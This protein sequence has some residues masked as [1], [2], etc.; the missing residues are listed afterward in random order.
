MAV[1]HANRLFL[2]QTIFDTLQMATQWPTCDEGSTTGHYL[3][4]ADALVELLEVSDCGSVGGFDR[5]NP[6]I[7]VTGCNVFD[8]FLTLLRK[9]PGDVKRIKPV[10]NATVATLTQFYTEL[11]T[12]RDKVYAEK[13]LR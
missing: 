2:L 12:L 4:K 7:R 8:R 13:G 9:R 1:K 5:T 6:N 10:C 3:A 11:H